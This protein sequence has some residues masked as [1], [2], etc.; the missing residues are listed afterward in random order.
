MRHY[1][2]HNNENKKGHKPNSCP[3]VLAQFAQIVKLVNN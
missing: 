1:Q 2:Q 3:S